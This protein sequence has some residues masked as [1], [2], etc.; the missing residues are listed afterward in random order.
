MMDFIDDDKSRVAVETTPPEAIACAPLPGQRVV[1]CQYGYDSAV[2]VVDQELLPEF[3]HPLPP[4]Q[5]WRDD[6]HMPFGVVKEVLADDNAS[7]D[8]LSQSD[9][10]GQQIALFGVLE[11]PPRDLNLVVV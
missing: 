7:L 5:G 11:H 4:Q 9:L 8:G 6:D 2:E 1:V 10:V 3:G